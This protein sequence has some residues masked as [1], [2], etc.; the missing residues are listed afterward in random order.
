[1]ETSSRIH[2]ERTK[3]HTK[4]FQIAVASHL[5]DSSVLQMSSTMRILEYPVW[6]Q[7]LSTNSIQVLNSGHSLGMHPGTTK[8]APF[9]GMYLTRSVITIGQYN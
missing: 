8:V 9:A 5:S 1:M 6:N 4:I 3:Y 2:L 7:V